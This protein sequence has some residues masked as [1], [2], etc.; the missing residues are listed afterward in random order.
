MAVYILINDDGVYTGSK[1]AVY[2]VHTVPRR[3]CTYWS[4]MQCILNLQ[5]IYGGVHSDPIWWCTYW[6]K[7]DLY[8]LA[9][10][11]V[12]TDPMGRITLMQDDGVYCTVL[13]CTYSTD[14][15]GRCSHVLYG[16]TDPKWWVYILT[17]DGGIYTDPRWRYICTLTQGWRVVGTPCGISPPTY[18]RKEETPKLFS[19][20]TQRAPE[21][22]IIV[23]KDD[24][25]PN[26]IKARS[27]WKPLARGGWVGWGVRDKASSKKGGGRR[28][29]G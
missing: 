14:T 8:I 27:L 15:R 28:G 24:L 10:D 1:M 29:R 26:K 25:R 12:H 4:K 2:N 3:L 22:N 11:A 7:V 17:Q 5:Y 20:L 23:S 19:Q 21:V 18:C 9:Q 6:P 13:L 16:Y